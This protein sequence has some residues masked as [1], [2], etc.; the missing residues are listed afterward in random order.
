MV[1]IDYVV[2]V[3]FGYSTELVFRADTLRNAGYIA[4][5]FMMELEKPTDYTISIEPNKTII[6]EDVKDE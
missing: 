3:K 1:K 5:T 4:D 2:R 6:E